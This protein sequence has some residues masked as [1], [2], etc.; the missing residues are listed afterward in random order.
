MSHDTA[1]TPRPPSRIP[2]VLVVDDEADLRELIEITLV[3][4]GLDVDCAANL[5]DAHRLLARGGYALCL[6]D[7]RL[8]DG[9]GLDVVATSPSSIRN[10]PVAVIT[11][12]GD[13]ERGGGAEG[14]RLRL[15]RQAGQ[16]RPAARPL[17]MSALKLPAPCSSAGGDRRDDAADPAAAARRIGA[18]PEVRREMIE[19]LARSQAPVYIT[20]ESGS[21]RNWPRALIHRLHGSARADA[22]LRRGQLRRDSR[23]PDGERVLRPPQGRV[24]RRRADRDGFF[25]AARRRHAVPRRGGRPAAADAGEAAARDPGEEGAQ[26]RRHQEE[27]V[28]VRIISA[29]H[30]KL[31]SRSRRASSGRTS[32]TGST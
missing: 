10:T 30:K 32:S 27:P 31:A 1:P 18:D 16:A 5:A 12:Y 14:R 17:V 8:P 15:S 9:E 11:A 29:T 21:A 28:D 4:M 20:G 25:Q 23:E 6:T 22:A 13:G 3:S 19:R 2:R 7:M 24:H 26:G